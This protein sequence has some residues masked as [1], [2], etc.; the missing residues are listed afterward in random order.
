[1][2]GLFQIKQKDRKDFEQ[3]S[4]TTTKKIVEEYIGEN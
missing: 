3:S 4:L 1:M 2:K